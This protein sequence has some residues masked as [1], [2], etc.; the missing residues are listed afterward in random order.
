MKELLFAMLSGLIV[1]IVF[2]LLR[3]PLPAPP[4]LAGIIG[5]FGIYLGG[6]LIE[7]INRILF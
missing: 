5:I 3:M 4:V 2:K 1:G 7:W 6:R